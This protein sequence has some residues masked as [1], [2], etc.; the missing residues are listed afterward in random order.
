MALQKKSGDGLRA[1]EHAEG[2]YGGGIRNA[3]DDKEA[4]GDGEEDVDAAADG[5]A[6]DDDMP[7]QFIGGA[8]K[9]DEG[10]SGKD[11]GNDGEEGDKGAPGVRHG[12]DM[13][14]GADNIEGDEE[15]E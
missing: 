10:D 4:A 14:V 13:H 2:A 7:P 9:A 11:D 6:G 1:N 12:V 8:N 3:R 15:R 5:E